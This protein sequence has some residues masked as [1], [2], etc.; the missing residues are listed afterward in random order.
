MCGQHNTNPPSTIL[1]MERCTKRMQ[2]LA[3]FA[4]PSAGS[5]P[6]YMLLSGDGVGALHSGVWCGVRTKVRFIVHHALCPFFLRCGRTIYYIVRLEDAASVARVGRRWCFVSQAQ[7]EAPLWFHLFWASA[8]EAW[9][10]PDNSI[11]SEPHSRSSYLVRS[12]T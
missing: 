3:P 12:L 4:A 10:S 11:D 9:V 7:E 2:F 5:A 6:Y 8:S 1:L